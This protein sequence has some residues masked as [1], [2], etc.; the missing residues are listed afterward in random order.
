MA[1]LYE[2]IA[3]VSI[4]L[5]D[6]VVSVAFS[7]I[8]SEFS[9]CFPVAARKENTGKNGKIMGKIFQEKDVLPERALNILGRIVI[10]FILSS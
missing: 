1:P 6:C 8:D 3:F 7:G 2:K 5:F 4:S 10:K 9:H